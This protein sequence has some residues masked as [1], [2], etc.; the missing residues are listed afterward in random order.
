MRGSL[1]HSLFRSVLLALFCFALQA[2][3][4]AD[5]IKVRFA[6]GLTRGFLSVSDESGK[7]IGDGE[8]QQTVQ[9]NRVTN[10]FVLRFKDGSSYD[11]TT[12]FTQDGVFHLLTDHLIEQGPAFKSAMETEIDTSKGQVTIRY[13]DSQGKDKTLSRHMELPSDLANGILYVLVKDMSPNAGPTTV[14]Y[15]A[16]TPEPRLV[17]LIF[18]REGKGAFATGGVRRDAEHYVVHVDIGGLTGTVARLIGRQPPNTDM[19]VIGGEAP[20]FAGSSGPLDGNGGSWK[21]SLV[22]PVLADQ[23]AAPIH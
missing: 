7:H 4:I 14:S 20:T 23:S 13:K 3:L 6:E 18:T 15:L 1:G 16:A 22:S 12:V 5:N 2:S 17:K 19:W 21:I 10:H 8:V 11:D 9:G